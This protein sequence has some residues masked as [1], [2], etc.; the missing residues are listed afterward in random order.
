MNNK[1][2]IIV[3]VLIVLAILLAFLLIDS[4]PVDTHATDNAIV[5]ADNKIIIRQRDSGLKVIDSLKEDVVKRDTLIR[6]L[7]SQLSFTRRDADKYKAN[8]VRLSN[9][10]KQL[11]DTSANGRRCDSLAS[12]ALNFAFLYEQYKA[13]GD[14]LSAV[15][16]KNSEDYVKAL[17]ERRRMYDELYIKYEQLYRLYNALYADHQQAGKKLRREK[18]KTKVAAVLGG[19]LAVL[20][21]LK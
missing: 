21:L 12:E 1:H 13:N 9:E 5:Q 8:V 16:D 11:K 20:A 18:L 14:S 2:A 3:G 19:A 15:V 17:E 6:E 7:K 4:K 10:I